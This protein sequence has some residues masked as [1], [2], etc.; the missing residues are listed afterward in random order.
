MK[1]KRYLHPITLRPIAWAMASMLT[2]PFSAQAL[3]FGPQGEFSLTGFG[4]VILTS[5]SNYCGNCQAADSSVNRQ[6]RSADALIPGVKYGSAVL[7]N[8]QVQPY[9]GYKRDL[10]GGYKFNALYSQ[11]WRQGSIDGVVDAN[12]KR[13]G[14]NVDVKDYDYESNLA[15]SHEDYGSVRIGHMTARSWSVADFPYG[16]QAGLAAAWGSSGAGYGMLGNAIR[17]AGPMLDVAGGDLFIEVTYDGGNTQWTRL[18]PQLLEFYAQY[19]KGDLVVDAMVQSGSNGAPGSWGHAPFGSITRIGTDDS[20]KTADGSS[21][22]FT[23]GNEQSIAMLM[24]R[25]QFTS[26]IEGSA[27]M[28]LNQ[29]SGSNLVWSQNAQE[30]VAFNV[31]YTTPGYQSY[32]ARSIDVLLGV[33][34]RWEAWTFGTGMVWL[35]TADTKN[36]S[37]RGQRNWALLNTVTANYDFG[38]GLQFE[39]TLG[40]V[41]YGRLGLAPFS[42][43]GNAAFS[44]VDSRVTQQGFWLTVGLVYGF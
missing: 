38:S 22:L 23:G 4:E 10:G 40:S 24:A 21:Y 34:Y 1:P 19:H 20:Q 3:E 15:L 30:T 29:W 28:R 39:S 12:E 5:Q 11:R 14:G 16:T 36:P 42:M 9:L 33:R 32:S 44:N 35:G 17:V 2:L 43:P 6:V 7:T 13:Y 26:K 18:K 41:Y 25:Y 37:E 27:G 8:W 31:D